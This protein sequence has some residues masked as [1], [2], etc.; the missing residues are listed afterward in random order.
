MPLQ[1]LQ[2]DEE[3]R[4]KAPE[5]IKQGMDA[6]N[7]VTQNQEAESVSFENLLALGRLERIAAG[8]V[9]GHKFELP[10]LPIP[11]KMNIHHRYDPV[12]DQVTNLI[13]LH[14]KL[15]VA[16]R[17]GSSVFLVSHYAQSFCVKSSSK[18]SANT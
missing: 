18:K 6:T 9:T 11:S 14:G 13:M 2:R 3:G 10:K 12:V 15:S 8:S 7:V 17:V 4:E 5:V 1:I 16:Q